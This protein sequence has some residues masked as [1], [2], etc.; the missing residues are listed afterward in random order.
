MRWVSEW[1]FRGN[2]QDMVNANKERV[3]TAGLERRGGASGYI[4]YAVQLRNI[5]TSFRN[6]ATHVS[7]KPSYPRQITNQYLSGFQSIYKMRSPSLSLLLPIAALCV[8]VVA[9]TISAQSAEELSTL[10]Q[11]ASRA[12]LTTLLASFNLIGNQSQFASLGA[13]TVLAPTNA[14]FEALGERILFGLK[15]SYNSD[16][17]AQIIRY[18]VIRKPLSTYDLIGL[19][20]KTTPETL[21]GPGIPVTQQSGNLLLGGAGIV[22]PNLP[23]MNGQAPSVAHVIDHVILPPGKFVVDNHA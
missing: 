11:L 10:E 15:Q 2:N 8:A 9:T 5:F 17:L 3:R 19:I 22:I 20:G 21:L 4:Y 14:A 7:K 18:H 13:V 23:F 16:I 6:R 12:G 1:V